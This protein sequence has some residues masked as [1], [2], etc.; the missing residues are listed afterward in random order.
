[1]KKR[2]SVKICGEPGSERKL[3]GLKL[4]RNHELKLVSK[5]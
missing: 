3:N 5:R 2:G 1:M 4:M